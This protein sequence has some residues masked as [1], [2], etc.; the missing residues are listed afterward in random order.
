MSMKIRFTME[1]KGCQ[2]ENPTMS[3]DKLFC[4]FYVQPSTLSF[5]GHCNGMKHMRKL[6]KSLNPSWCP[7]MKEGN[8]ER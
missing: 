7:M 5:E 6:P 8:H 3:G 2:W 4:P 1:I